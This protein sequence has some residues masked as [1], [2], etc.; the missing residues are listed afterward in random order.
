MKRT[1][2]GTLE[3][4]AVELREVTLRVVGDASDQGAPRLQL[5]YIMIHSAHWADSGERVFKSL[6]DLLDNMT[7]SQ[8]R[9]V[10]ELVGLAAGLADRQVP[11][12][13][14]TNGTGEEAAGP[15]H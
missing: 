11:A 14:P 12:P 4:R 2:Q 1:A 6:D 10:N 13:G 9:E 7:I 5:Y 15:P 8:T 3:G